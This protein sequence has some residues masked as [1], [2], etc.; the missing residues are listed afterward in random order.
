MQDRFQ[1][2]SYLLILSIFVLTGTLTAQ[3]PSPYHV[4]WERDAYYLGGG[5]GVTLLGFHL[6]ANTPKLKLNDLDL[7]KVNSFD[8]IA[9]TYSSG[10][11]DKLSDHTMNLSVGLSIVF[12][13]KKRSRKDFGNVALLFTE[14]MLWNQGL[15]DIIKSTSRRPRPYIFDEN[16][17][18]AK[19]LSSNDRAS[20]VSGHT[21]GATAAAFFF[22]RTFSDYYPESP[23]KPYVWGVSIA[24]PALTGYLRVRGGQHYPT[25]VIAG[26]LLGGTI[27]YLIP[28]LHKSPLKAKGLSLHPTGQG[29]YLSYRF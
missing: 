23:W 21:S 10:K 3:A 12:L 22:A 17:D 25:D 4:S 2:Y 16:I 11:A 1:K 18:P 27:G 29:V 28:S 7:G 24:L 14:T 5:L 6:K 13:A 26:Y 19:V 8:R 15:T 20:F 9:T